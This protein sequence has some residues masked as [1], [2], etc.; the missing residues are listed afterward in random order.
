M[1]D[2]HILVKTAA[3]I[4]FAYTIECPGRPDCDSRIE[5]HKDHK[6]DGRDADDGPDDCEEGD[7]WCGAEEWEFH[8]AFHLWMSEYGWTIPAGDCGAKTHPWLYDTASDLLHDRPP[9][10]YPVR[11]SWAEEIFDLDLLEVQP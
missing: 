10:R 1:T 11:V 3:G 5:C 6:V 9:G 4:G 8:G 2:E 7:P